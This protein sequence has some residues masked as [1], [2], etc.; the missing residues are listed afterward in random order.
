MFAPAEDQIPQHEQRDQAGPEE[1]PCQP[2]H[3][4]V[5]LSLS[6]S[7]RWHEEVRQ[8]LAQEETGSVKS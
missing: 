8:L 7:P 6:S 4:A 1:Y 5:T 2:T 3:T